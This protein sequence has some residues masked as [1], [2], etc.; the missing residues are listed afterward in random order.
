MARDSRR[1]LLP[2]VYSKKCR[3]QRYSWV[4]TVTSHEQCDDCLVMS[5]VSL[6]LTLVLLRRR[7]L[8]L[9]E[10]ICRHKAESRFYCS[11][12]LFWIVLLCRLVT[13]SHYLVF[14]AGSVCGVD[15]LTLVEQTLDWYEWLFVKWINL[16][17]CIREDLPV[18]LWLHVDQPLNAGVD[19]PLII[20][21]DQPLSA[22]VDQPLTSCRLAF[23]MQV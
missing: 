22:G 2:L 5:I 9:W 15:E 3:H 21:I 1:A 19:Q 4:V 16:S 11:K 20:H 13:I 14:L 17:Y 12:L 7:I 8:Q 23:R 10:W 18:C 6:S